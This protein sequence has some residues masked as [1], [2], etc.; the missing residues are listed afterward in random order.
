MKKEQA[1]QEYETNIYEPVTTKFIQNTFED[2]IDKRIRRQ[3]E[4]RKALEEF[5]QNIGRMQ[6]VQPIPAGQIAISFLRTSIWEEKPR[7]RLDCY[8][9]G[10]EAGRNLACQYIDIDWLLPHWGA[11]RDELVTGVKGKEYDRYIRTAQINQYMS[12]AL[13]RLFGMLAMSL[14]YDLL[15]ADQFDGYEDLV[16]DEVFILTAGEYLDWQKVLFA[17]VPEVDIV[18]NP[19][20]V[21]VLYQKCSKKIYRKK[22]FEKMNLAKSRF[23]ECE[24]SKCTFDQ[25]NLTDTRFVDCL[26]RDV[27]MQGGELYGAAFI[28]CVFTN[29]DFGDMKMKWVPF[30]DGKEEEEEIYRNTMF[31]DCIRDNHKMEQEEEGWNTLS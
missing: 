21:P 2:Y 23:I 24:F 11:Y 29:I 22:T 3:E 16:K 1:L 26:F 13:D 19:Q 20:D 4:L 8:D 6:K 17:D 25:V 14:K 7:L 5:M 10:K 27:T 31:V 28:H 9:A 30:Q 12:R 15:D 18:A